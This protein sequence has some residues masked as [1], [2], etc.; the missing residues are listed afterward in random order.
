MANW[1]FALSL[2]LL[3][4]ASL[5]TIKSLLT[6][7]YPQSN[8]LSSGL[9]WS[10]TNSLKHWNRKKLILLNIFEKVHGDLHHKSSNPKK[11]I[12]LSKPVLLSI[13]L[14]LLELVRRMSDSSSPLKD[15]DKMAVD[16]PAYN[17]CGYSITNNSA[18]IA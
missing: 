13:S 14:R 9:S 7:K 8:T 4:H 16:S 2:S 18:T 6:P 17:L 1:Q 11:K 10:E 12:F 5:S 15:T 3:L